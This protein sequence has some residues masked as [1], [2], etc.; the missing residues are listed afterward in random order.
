MRFSIFFIL[1]PIGGFLQAQQLQL[2]YDFRHTLA[3]QL[4]ARNFLSMNFEYFTDKDTTGSFLLKVQADFNGEDNNV[5]QIF[6][7]VSKNFRFWKPK[8]Y[9]SVGYSGGLGIAP[10]SFGYSIANAYTLGVSYPFQWKGFYCS[11]ISG[12][13]Y[14]RFPKGSHDGHLTFY[15]WKGLLDYKMSV[16][17]S[18]VGWTQNRD[19]G[20]DFTKHLTGKKAAFFADPQIW[21][22]LGGRW[23]IGTKANCFYH[24]LTEDNSLQVYPTFGIKAEL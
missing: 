17:G 3:P 7:Q 19:L 9:L 2:H 13:R 22:K 4:N 8:L 23:S 1:L 12:Y 10:P 20:I 24:V 14:N 6:M 16:S 15:F 21:L 18:F 11:I 5:S